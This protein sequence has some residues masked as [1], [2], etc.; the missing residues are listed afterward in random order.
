MSRPICLALLVLSLTQGLFADTDTLR[1]IDVGTAGY[2]KNGCWTPI[3]L[4][5]SR[6]LEGCLLEIETVDSDGVTTTYRKEYDETIYKDTLYVK[7]GRAA[8]PLKLRLYQNPGRENPE[9]YLLKPDIPFGRMKSV[10][11]QEPFRL[12]QPVPTERPIFLIVGNDNIALQDAVAQLLLPENRRPVLVK[13][14][15]LAQLPDRIE[16]FEAFNMIVLTTTEPKAYEGVTRESPQLRALEHWLLFGGHVFFIAGSEAEPLV[17]NGGILESFLPGQF[18][19]MTDLRQGEIIELFTGSKRPLVMTGSEEMPFLRMP[20]FTDT[21]GVTVQND[22]DLAI[23]VRSPRGFG[24]LTYLGGDLSRAPLLDWRDRDR[25]VSKVLGWDN[26]MTRGASI[27]PVTLMHLGYSDLSGQLR[28]ALDRFDGVSVLPFSLILILMTVYVLAVAPLDWFVVHRILK[29]PILT[30]YTFPAWVLLFSLLAYFLGTRNRLEKPTVNSISLHDIDA[31]SGSARECDWHTL[32]SP[33]DA[34][35]DVTSKQSLEKNRAL[36]VI[37]SRFSWLGLSGSGLGGMNPKTYT[38]G[39]WD[40]PY[41]LNPTER[42]VERVPVAVRSTKSFFAQRLY[43]PVSSSEQQLSG[44]PV[45]QVALKEEQGIPVGSL[46]LEMDLDNVQLAFD[47]W[48]IDVGT[49][50]K[51]EPLSIG[52]HNPRRELKEVLYQAGQ[53]EETPGQP[54]QFLSYRMQSHDPLYILKAMTLFGAVGGYDAIG[55]NHAYQSLLDLSGLLKTDRVIL[56]GTTKIVEPENDFH[57]HGKTSSK[58]P[59]AGHAT[60][61]VRIL[62]PI[63]LEQRVRAE[64]IQRGILDEKD[65]KIEEHFVEP[66]R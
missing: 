59:A 8:A 66:I 54:T 58:P 43:R 45:K 21:E 64:E 31:A 15:S 40:E 13:I 19:K 4:E 1:L 55:L 3:H 38:P 26:Q 51:G 2:Y 56:V 18:D 65:K 62:L 5:A 46:L 60:R 6:S 44:T 23:V 10:S 28:S 35:Y 17:R 36:R 29:K 52:T 49:I 53:E 11:E 32:Y 25:L 41:A 12:T 63:A 37:S 39:L 30:W 16:G 47:R 48:I 34:R 9:E 14:D 57:V 27:Q 20:H 33:I 7:P 22:G 50:R 61:I 42:P 24:R